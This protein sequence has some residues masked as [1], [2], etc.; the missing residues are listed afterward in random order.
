MLVFAAELL[1]TPGPNARNARVFFASRLLIKY[2]VRWLSP[3]GVLR[4]RLLHQLFKHCPLQFVTFFSS[5]GL[6]VT[7]RQ[8]DRRRLLSS[9]IILLSAFDHDVDQQPPPS[10]RLFTERPLIKLMG[11]SSHPCHLSREGKNNLPQTTTKSIQRRRRPRQILFQTN[12][13]RRAVF[14]HVLRFFPKCQ[15]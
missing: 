9:S 7:R 4:L 14:S 11:L 5:A 13:L 10:A 3:L 15:P 1:W 12:V 2:G 6:S 8:R